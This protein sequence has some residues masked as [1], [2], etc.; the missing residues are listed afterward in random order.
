MKPCSLLSQP[1]T[2]PLGGGTLL[3]RGDG[4]PVEV[5]DLQSL[6]LNAINRKG[7]DLE[8]GAM[9][10]LQQ[11]LE[12]SECPADLKTA[13]KLEAP[14]NLRNS[15]S[16]AGTL[17]TCSGRSTFAGALLALDAKLTLMNPGPSGMALGEYL[18]LRPAG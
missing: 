3:S 4:Q 11:L 18:P 15:A 14:L 8:I 13:I 16:A 7:N 9:V 17:V 5:V 1:N 2:L 6:G 12:S 10:T